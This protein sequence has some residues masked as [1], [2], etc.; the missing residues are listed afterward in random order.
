MKAYKI[1]S[2]FCLCA[3]LCGCHRTVKTGPDT[4]AFVKQILAQRTSHVKTLLTSFNASSPDGNIVIID[5]PER[6][7]AIADKFLGS[8]YYDNI[9]AKSNPDL[10]PDF[11]G[12]TIAPMG[13]KF[14]SGSEEEYRNLAVRSVIDAVDS[15]YD[16][17]LV[18]IT[19][20]ELSDIGVFDV[21]TL[22]TSTG[23]DLPVIYPLVLASAETS[24]R[25]GIIASSNVSK[26]YY[27][28]LFGSDAFIYEWDEADDAGVLSSLLSEYLAQGSAAAL[29]CIVIDDFRFSQA[30]INEEWHSLLT[31]E[32]AE[33]FKLRQAT[34][35]DFVIVDTREIA[36][37]AVFQVLRDRNLFTHKVAY[38]QL[39]KDV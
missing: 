6:A 24:G 33:N 10:L 15:L 4:T 7:S 18:V 17:K 12:E 36:A 16:A 1:I 39:R 19:A 5:A 38:P 31:E 3:I 37:K 28:L 30:Q 29:S 14:Q 2:F 20:P 8:D 35:K 22:L 13:I 34:T 26:E 32:N 25:V 9:D 27:R 11:A 23:A 21:D